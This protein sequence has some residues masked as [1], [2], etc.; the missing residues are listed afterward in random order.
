MTQEFIGSASS[1]ASN[2]DMAVRYDV[3]TLGDLLSDSNTR[4]TSSQVTASTVLT[5][6]LEEASGD[7]ELACIAGERYLPEDLD[8][9]EGVSEQKLIGLVCDIA[10]SRLMD[11]RPNVISEAPRRVK[12]AFDTL[13]ML[14]EGARIFSLGG[15]AEA[16][17]LVE[18]VVETQCLVSQG[19]SRMLGSCTE[20]SGCPSYTRPCSC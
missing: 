4:L 20:G 14:R 6:L 13:N 5:A 2:D 11:R 16:G 18:R 8:A 3:R 7:I 19:A 1:Y 10:F 17:Y 15:A 12:D 9:L